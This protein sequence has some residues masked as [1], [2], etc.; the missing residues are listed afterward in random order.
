MSLISKRENNL[1]RKWAFLRH[2]E[3]A[4]MCGGSWV[5]LR[6][7]SE[8]EKSSYNRDKGSETLCYKSRHLRLI[9]VFGIYHRISNSIYT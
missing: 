3:V 8:R 6:T 4:D 5:R 7:A 2:P 9:I 1:Q